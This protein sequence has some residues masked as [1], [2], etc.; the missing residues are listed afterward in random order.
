MLIAAAL[1]ELAL[2]EAGSLKDKRRV[3]RAVKDRLRARFNVA[4]AEVDDQDERHS[5]CLGLA[6]V[7]GDPRHLRA[8]LEKAIRYVEGLGLAEVIGDD[9]LVARLDEVPALDEAEDE[10]T[11]PSAWSEE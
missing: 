8:R 11:V 9:V 3:V 1:L 2:G 4:V 6:T 10:D 7:G 5:I